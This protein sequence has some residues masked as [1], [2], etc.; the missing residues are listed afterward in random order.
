[1]R[2]WHRDNYRHSLAA[3]GFTQPKYAKSI[4]YDKVIAEPKYDGTR[5]ILI[6]KSGSVK[7]VNRRDVDKTSIYPE[8]QKMAEQVKG[9]AVLDGEMVVVTKEHPYGDFHALST[10]D[11]L[12]DMDAVE[13]RSKTTPV[14]YVAFDILEKDNKDLTDKTLLERKELLDKT[15]KPNHYV[16]EI[17]YTNDVDR[18]I[19]DIKKSKGEGV[20]IKDID[21]KYHNNG[22]WQKH[23]F[24]RINDVAV[25]GYTKGTG[26]RK[27]YFGALKVSINSPRGL[28]PVGKVGTGFTHKDLQEIKQRLDSG[29]KLVARVEY[30]KT[31]SQGRYIEPRFIGLRTDI[32]QRQTHA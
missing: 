30:R 20:V 8:A 27:P 13:E 7:L 14:K 17:S 10:R 1:M 31:G 2:G 11:R 12:Q 4:K 25:T 32:T 22:A 6:K 19:K 18:L 28:R 23:K 9:D 29:E 24:T 3:R 5:M 15:V 16:A 21:S 26:A